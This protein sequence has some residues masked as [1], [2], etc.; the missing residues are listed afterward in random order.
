MV[1]VHSGFQTAV[2][3]EHCPVPI[4]V[5]SSFTEEVCPRPA[6]QV[7]WRVCEKPSILFNKCHFYLNSPVLFFCYFLLKTM[8]SELASFLPCGSTE[9]DTQCSTWMII[10]HSAVGSL[11]FISSTSN[12]SKTEM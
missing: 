12:Q 11:K 4:D 1:A 2:F 7:S 3:L 9:K 8:S 6:L 10:S 5:S